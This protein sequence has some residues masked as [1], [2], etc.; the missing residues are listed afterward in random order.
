MIED[1]IVAIS[2]P[3]GKSGVG[4]VRIS[5]KDSLLI[6]K[7]MFNS[8]RELNNIQPNYMNLGRINLG[9]IS[10]LGFMVYF[11]GPKSFTGED[12]VE[13]QCHGGIIV[14]Q[15]IVEQAIHFGARLAQKA[16]AS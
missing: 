7:K 11:K 15:K 13:F 6:A 1:T 8:K 9:Q 14:T 3:Y 2:T 16:K 4:V 10:D 12:V 5:G